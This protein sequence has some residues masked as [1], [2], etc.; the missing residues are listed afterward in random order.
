MGVR[1][2]WI[3]SVSLDVFEVFLQTNRG[4]IQAILTVS[5]KQPGAVMWVPGGSENFNGPAGGIYADLVV[6]L[7]DAGMSSLRM[8]LRQQNTFEECVLDALAWLCF[9]RGA[10]T[11]EIVLVGNARGAA[12]AIASAALHPQVK[13][14]VAISPQQDDTD[15]V[16]RIG[17]RPILVIHGGRDNRVPVE[18][19]QD[20]YNRAS[21]PKELVIFPNG[22]ATLLESRGELREKLGGWASQQLGLT[23]AYLAAMQARSNDYPDMDKSVRPM[24]GGPARQML[25]TRHDIVDMDVEA[26]VSTTG[27][28]LDMSTTSLARSITERGGSDIQDQLWALAPLFVGDVGVTGAGHLKA[29]HVFHA[30]TGGE[31]ADQELDR[32]EAVLLTTQGALQEANDLGLKTIALPAIGT[33]GRGFPLEK[34]A[35]IMVGVIT[36]HLLGETTLEK[37]TIGVVS[38]GVYRAFGSQFSLLTDSARN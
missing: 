4:M 10:G 27:T 8:G 21:D 35:Q 24:G 29:K 31:S 23:D 18:V 17:P 2:S 3:K 36:A 25:L 11:K 12:V 37:V 33:G 26:I 14:V 15:M 1:Q 5:Q 34:A 9:L 6:E 32:N 30:I 16:D 22:S 28:W 7:Q 20:V 19:A 38:D 13:A